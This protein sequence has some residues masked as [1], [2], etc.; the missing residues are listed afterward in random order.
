L[1]RSLKRIFALPIARLSLRE[2][3]NA[4]TTSFPGKQDLCNAIYN[5]LLTSKKSDLL[6]DEGDNDLETLIDNYSVQVRFA[7]EV[8]DMG[9]FMNIFSCDFVQ[10]GNQVFF[11]NRM[12]R[13]DGEEYYFLSAPETNIRLA[14]MF[15]NRLRD[16]KRQA[17]K[18]V[19]IDSRLKE[20]LETMISDT[21]ELLN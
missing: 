8:A 20:E 9:D 4:I 14:H 21:K 6:A 11:T 19:K 1:N 7:R 17:G 3:Q 13:I 10:Q 2:V 15:I 16:L 18:D 12:R 5:S